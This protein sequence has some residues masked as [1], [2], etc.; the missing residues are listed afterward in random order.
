MPDE[1]ELMMPMPVDIQ[2]CLSPVRAYWL[3]SCYFISND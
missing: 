3:R 1:V 2:G